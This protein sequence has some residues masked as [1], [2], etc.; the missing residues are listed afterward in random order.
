LFPCENRS[1]VRMVEQQH[2]AKEKAKAEAELRVQK[3]DEKDCEKKEVAEDKNTEAGKTS[4]TT[5]VD[6]KKNKERGLRNFVHVPKKIKKLWHDTRKKKD[7]ANVENLPTTSTT[8]TTT[9]TTTTISTTNAGQD[10]LDEDMTMMTFNESEVSASQSEA[11]CNPKQSANDEFVYLDFEIKARYPKLYKA[12]NLKG[13]TYRRDIKIN[14]VLIDNTCEVL[15]NHKFVRP[16]TNRAGKGVVAKD[17]D[18]ALVDHST[19]GSASYDK[20]WKDPGVI[21]GFLTFVEEC[22]PDFHRY[23]QLL[24]EPKE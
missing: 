5:A 24:F 13:V 23:M 22:D 18:T 17:K 16:S 7:Q 4:T 6:R 19:H 20:W 21:E 14:P 2:A 1:A 15:R 11:E 8:T 3:T 12:I 9:T 10:Y